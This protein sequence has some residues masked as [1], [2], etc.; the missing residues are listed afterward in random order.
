MATISKFVKHLI[1]DFVGPSWVKARI[2]WHR[3]PFRFS[4]TGTMIMSAY[5]PF[6]IL[7]Y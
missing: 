2:P 6:Y 5:L 7:E 3:S 4:L 1:R